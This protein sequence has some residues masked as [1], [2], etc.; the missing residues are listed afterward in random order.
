MRHRHCDNDELNSLP[1]PD[2]DDDHDEHRDH[3][4]DHEDAHGIQLAAALEELGPCF[5]KL[6]QLL[7]S[8]PELLPADYIRALSRPQATIQPVPCARIVR[9][10]ESGLRAPINTLFT[11]VD[12]RPLA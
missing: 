3:D 12:E 8:R 7:S 2:H 10:I 4:H 6:G 5:I 1:A 9:T 11:G